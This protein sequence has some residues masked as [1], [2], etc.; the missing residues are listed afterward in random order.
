MAIDGIL[1]DSTV[2]ESGQLL[3]ALKGWNA[4]GAGFLARSTVI[5]TGTRIVEE[6]NA[7]EIRSLKGDLCNSNKYRFWSLNRDRLELPIMFNCSREVE[8]HERT[9]TAKL[10]NY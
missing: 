9:L 10:L 5:Q 1:I 8:R 6:N 4:P 7:L 3:G 2:L